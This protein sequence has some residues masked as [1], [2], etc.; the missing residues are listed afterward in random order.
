MAFFVKSSGIF[1][2]SAEII[3]KF[4]S[5]FWKMHRF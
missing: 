4:Q 2:V 5:N 3:G 1:L